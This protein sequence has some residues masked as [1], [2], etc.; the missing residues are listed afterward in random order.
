MFHQ[1]FIVNK[2]Q[3]LLYR[4]TYTIGRYQKAKM[5]TCCP[6]FYYIYSIVSFQMKYT[7][8]VILALNE[9]KMTLKIK[10]FAERS[11]AQKYVKAFSR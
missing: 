9:C 11:L 3:R 7:Y 4:S 5:H 8:N 2:R 10:D 1:C 6:T